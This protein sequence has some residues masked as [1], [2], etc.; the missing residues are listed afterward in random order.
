MVFYMFT[1]FYFIDGTYPIMTI[2]MVRGYG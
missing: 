1:M 2:N